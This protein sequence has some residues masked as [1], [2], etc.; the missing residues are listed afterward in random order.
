MDLTQG[1]H[2]EKTARSKKMML[3][4]GIGSLIMSFA[5]LVSAF[6]TYFVK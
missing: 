3:W 1:T 5:G 4:F 2:Q 6:S